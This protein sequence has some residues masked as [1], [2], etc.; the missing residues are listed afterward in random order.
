MWEGGGGWG[1][2]VVFA[3]FVIHCI[4]D[5]ISYSF[6]V[7]YVDL[8]REF[9]THSHAQLLLVGSLLPATCLFIGQ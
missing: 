2:A 3:A 4:V 1:V 8:L 7:F 5:G 6:A 9:S